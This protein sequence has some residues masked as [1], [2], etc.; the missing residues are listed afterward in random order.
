M[1]D[2]SESLRKAVRNGL[3][4][5]YCPR[6]FPEPRENYHRADCQWY[7]TLQRIY[8]IERAEEKR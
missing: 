2:E 3:V 6:E 5:C 7:N 4:A 1:S 8:E